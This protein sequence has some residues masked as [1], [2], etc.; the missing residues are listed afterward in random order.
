MTAKARNIIGITAFVLSL[1]F[2]WVSASIFP[3]H[4]SGPPVVRFVGT[5]QPFSEQGAGGLNT[6]TVF[7]QNQKWLFQVNRVD[8]VTGSDPGMM[9]LNYIFPPQLR[10]FGPPNRIAPLENPEI[11]GKQVTLEGFLYIP[12]RTF[13]VASANIAS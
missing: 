3:P 2:A 6:L 4:L 9:L 8:T 13:Y 5:F 1:G 10:F 7:V 11:A 12:D